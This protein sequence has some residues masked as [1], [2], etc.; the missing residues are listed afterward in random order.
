M[1]NV[2]TSA[3]ILAA[4]AGTRMMSNKT[5]QLIDI[6]GMTVLE[7]TLMAF[8]SSKLT[9]EIVVVAREGEID[10]IKSIVSSYNHSK[11]IKVTCGGSC[12]AE[13]AKNGFGIIDKSSEFIAIHD[14]ARC[15]IT[16]EMIDKVV[17]KAHKYGAATAVCGVSD[18]VKTV[19]PFGKVT[20]TLPR[21]N[22]FRAQTPQVFKTDLY[23][24]AID[25]TAELSAVTDDN[26][27]LEGIGAEIYAV[28]LGPTNIKITTSFDLTL[29][30][31]IL[32]ERGDVFVDDLRIGHGYD[33]HRLVEGRKLIVGGV[34]IPHT[35]GLLG[36]SDADVLIHAI[37][38]SL[39]GAAALGDIGMHF[40]DTDEKYRGISSMHLLTCV[41]DLIA[42]KGFD[43]VNVDATLV[44]Q[45][46]KVAGYI[47]KMISNIAFALGVDESRVNVKATTEERLGFTGREEG[48]KAHSVVMLR[49]NAN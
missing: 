31:A 19:D 2:K 27:L 16:P 44:L 30:K 8:S 49:K 12:R 43:V 40:P 34:E 1:S 37:M 7:R 36:H 25:K 15:L 11:P 5:K 47:P 14:A 41:R 22:I 9:D 35:K 23:K 20:A 3:I 13:S 4:G 26:M 45:S 48:A 21:D 10:E 42:E 24:E 32:T 28:D 29:A 46:P 17:E 18:T 38:D 39:L 6:C 33:V